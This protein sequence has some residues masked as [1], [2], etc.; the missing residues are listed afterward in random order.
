MND[1]H[2]GRL[3]ID[4]SRFFRFGL[5]CTALILLILILT[6]CDTDFPNALVDCAGDELHIEFL[7]GIV[8]DPDLTIG[9]Q[10]QILDDLCI[11]DEDIQDFILNNL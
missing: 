8:D 7:Q 4:S 3:Q 11:V 6:G 2:V 5:A 9:E 10:R 1:T